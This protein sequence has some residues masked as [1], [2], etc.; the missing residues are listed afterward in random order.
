VG[1]TGVPTASVGCCADLDAASGA[2]RPGLAGLSARVVRRSMMSP[3]FR[4]GTRTSAVVLCNRGVDRRSRRMPLAPSGWRDPGPS[5][6][7]VEPGGPIVTPGMLLA[8]TRV[9]RWCADRSRAGGHRGWTCRGRSS[10]DHRTTGRA[11]SAPPDAPAPQAPPSGRPPAVRGGARRPRGRPD[12]APVPT[13]PG[14]RPG[15]GRAPRPGAGAPR[16]HGVRRLR[17]LIANLGGRAHP[18]PHNPP[19]ERVAADLRRL[20]WQHDLV[21]RHQD[22]AAPA[23]RVWA[24]ETAITRR[25]TQAARALEVPY[26]E[27]PAYRGLD[28]PQLH[29]LLRALADQGLVLPATVGLMVRDGGR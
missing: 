25:A 20:L 8:G 1:F 6:L 23:K 19:I 16:R 26:P 11:A 18:H 10:D 13:G 15:H 24:L 14:R 5:Q 27:P 3:R 7:G 9:A 2:V 22:V 21:V 28:R 17:R 12:P 29:S 4:R